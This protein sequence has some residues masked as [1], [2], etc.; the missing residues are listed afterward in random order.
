[1]TG[2]GDSVPMRSIT[3]QSPGA[4]G[5]FDIGKVETSESTKMF[6]NLV[7]APG[8][9]GVDGK[10]DSISKMIPQELKPTAIFGK[11]QRSDAEFQLVEAS[12][13]VRLRICQQ[14]GVIAEE[15]GLI[16]IMGR[17]E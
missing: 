7:R 17:L 16:R 9:I 13:N 6:G 2:T 10:L 12:G 4:I 11:S 15:K 5:L 3:C 8:S 14:R 1:M